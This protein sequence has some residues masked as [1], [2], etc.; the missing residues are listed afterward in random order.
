MKRYLSAFLAALL[1]VMLAAC[2]VPAQTPVGASY[3]AALLLTGDLSDKFFYDSVSEAFIRLRDELGENAFNY[4]ISQLGSSAADQSDWGPA[5]L[6]Y[7]ESKQYDVIIMGGW[8]ALGPLEHAMAM[9]PDQKF[10]FFDET[11]DFDA[12]GN[13]QNL[14]N[15]VF[16]ANEAAYLVGAAAALMLEDKDI[17]NISSSEK[18]LGFLGG[19][20]NR[21]VNDF[22]VGYTQ[23]AKDI[24]PD[25]EIVTAYVGNHI[26]SLRGKDLAVI[27]YQSGVDIGFNAAGSAGIGQMEAA[28][29]HHKYAFGTEHDQAALLPGYTKV[30]PSSAIKHIG[31]T[32]N[33][34]I[35]RDIEGALPYGTVESLGLSE[36]GVGIAKNTQYEELVPEK[37]REQI[38]ALEQDIIDG[39][40]S[41]NTAGKEVIQ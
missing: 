11:F 14:Y 31:I 1:T 2:S 12:N 8:Q 35:K 30:I 34:A 18:K 16:R 29:E 20:N 36:G 33:L 26:D 7:C 6:D 27:Q 32:L 37:I 23:G 17:Q 9:Y 24:N 15:V 10:I 28:F 13:P 38:D 25:I 5:V 22:L 40:I 4:K 41:V 19:V 21:A 39:R 3:Q